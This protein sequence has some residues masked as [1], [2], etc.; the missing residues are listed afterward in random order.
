MGATRTDYFTD[1]Q[2]EIATLAKALGHPARIAIME[3]LLKVDA[4]ICGDIVN[5]L[6]LAQPTVSQHLK[7]LKNAGLIKGDI[8]GN[9]I[10]YCIDEKAL[11]KLQ[12]YFGNIS[13]KLEKKKNNCC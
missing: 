12:V 4:C 3:Y 6:P 11:N 2:N 1:K 7:E 8:E 9:T 10:C 5:E 13:A